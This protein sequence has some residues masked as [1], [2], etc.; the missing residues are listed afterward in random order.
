MRILSLSAA[1]AVALSLPVSAA[2]YSLTVYSAAQP[3]SLSTERLADYGDRLPGYALVRD[4]REMSLPQGAGEVRFS[5][6]AK[7]IDP[8]TVSFASL[9][10]PSGTRVIEQNYQYDLVDSQKLLQRYLGQQITVERLRGEQSDRISGRLLS[11]TGGLILARE[12]GSVLTLNSWSNVEFPAL[13]GGLMSKP[14]LVWT[15]DAQHGGKHDAQV[16]Y[17]TQGMTWWTDY[18][19][20]LSGTAGVCKL[21]LQAWVSLVNQSGASYPNAQL[22]LVAGEVNRAPAPAE[23]VVYDMPVPMAA[24]APAA[25]SFAESELFEYHLYTLGRR[26]DLPDNSV[27]QLELFPSILG[28]DCQ[29]ELVFTASPQPYY[30]SGPNLDQ[31]FAATQKGEVNAYLLFDNKESNRMGLPLPGGRV[32]VNQQNAVDGSLEFI[33]EDLIEHTPRGETLRLTLGKSFDVVGERK[34][35]AFAYDEKARRIVEEFEIELRNGKK[36]AVDLTL[37]E[38]LYRWSDW[39]ISNAS[40]AYQKQD[41]KTID[42]AVSV[43]AEGKRTVRYSVAYQW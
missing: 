4:R 15:L 27:K 9:T 23:R 21:D 7:R 39:K 31:N 6:V 11:A 30:W 32:R 13:P 22:K 3:G 10:D 40:Q 5:D 12:D 14:T 17:Q 16:S 42:F 29:R 38:Y 1:I 37:R 36:T 33:G 24:P 34:Q 25:A 26:T 19:A 35:T 28:A 8:T 20:T 41:A 2:D 18:N 43:P